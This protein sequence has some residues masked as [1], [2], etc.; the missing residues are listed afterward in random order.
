MREKLHLAERA[1][2]SNLTVLITGESG[3]GKE[4]LAQAIHA[5]GARAKKPMVSVNCAALPES[6]LESEL[7][8]H[9]RGAFTGAHENRPGLAGEANGSTLFLDEIG[10]LPLPLQGKLLRFLQDGSYLP[11]GQCRPLGSDARV[12][13]ATNVDLR[14]RV[15]QARFRA[16]LYYRVSAFPIHLPPLRERPE[17]IVLLV[18]HF[19]ERIA[20]RDGR[21]IPRLARDAIDYLTSRRWTGNVREL[22]HLVERALLMSGESL[23]T[24][25]D[26]QALDAVEEL[27]D[28]SAP[29]VLPEGGVDLPG[30]VRDL[31]AAALRVKAGNVAAAA[32]LLGLSRPTLRY[33]MKKYGFQGV[34]AEERGPVG[35]AGACEPG[36]RTV[37]HRAC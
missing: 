30:I 19:L 8:G 37:R 25:R 1:S 28:A 4:L 34:D 26:F 14:Q 23:L 2:A 3:T 6:L 13:V 20:G 11:L 35:T 15:E 36:A 7:F 18:H 31:V 12:I 21:P 33:R 5:N 32:R 27:K 16:D 24:A 29:S 22:E 17:D 10:D 9:R